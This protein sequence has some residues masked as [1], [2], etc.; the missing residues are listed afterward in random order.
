LAGFIE[1]GA[2]IATDRWIAA[3]AGK[4]IGITGR[5]TPGASALHHHRPLTRLTQLALRGSVQPG[6]KKPRVPRSMR[7]V[8][9]ICVISKVHVRKLLQI[10]RLQKALYGRL[11]HRFKGRAKRHTTP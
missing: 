10:K 11:S 2:K 8:R 9:Q 7:K 5:G 4:I 3:L 6:L 1:A